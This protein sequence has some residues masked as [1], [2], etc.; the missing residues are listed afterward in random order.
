MPG[1]QLAGLQRSREQADYE[2]AIDFTSAEVR[3]VLTLL[4]GLAKDAEAILRHESLL[5]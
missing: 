5:D 2:S 1:W 3:S 4:S